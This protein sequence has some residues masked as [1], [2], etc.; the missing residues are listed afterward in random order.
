MIV[1]WNYENKFEIKL[2]EELGLHLSL[3]FVVLQMWNFDLYIYLFTF[4]QIIPLLYQFYKNIY[5]LLLFFFN[6]IIYYA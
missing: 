6:Y 4:K 3:L 1:L 2:N 5:L